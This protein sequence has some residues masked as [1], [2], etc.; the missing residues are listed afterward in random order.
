MLKHAKESDAFFKILQ[1]IGEGEIVVV[2]SIMLEDEIEEIKEDKKKE[3]VKTLL[4]LAVITPRVGDSVKELRQF[5]DKT[6]HEEI[7]ER[8]KKR[9]MKI[10]D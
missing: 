10:T 8:L 6:T 7:L 2:G 3:A 9:G 5:R 1:K 4:Y